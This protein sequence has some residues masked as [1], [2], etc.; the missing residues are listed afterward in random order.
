MSSVLN[1]TPVSLLSLDSAIIGC[2]K[3]HLTMYVMLHGIGRDESQS[4][5]LS[6]FRFFLERRNDQNCDRRFM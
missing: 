2:H 5:F 1:G 6:S 4:H 3:D